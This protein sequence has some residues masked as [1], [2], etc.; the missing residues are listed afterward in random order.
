MEKPAIS[1]ARAYAQYA[2]DLGV[3]PSKIFTEERSQETLGN[4]LF[5]KMQILLPNDWKRIIVVPQ[6]NHM[7]DR[8]DYILQKVL[9]PDYE[10]A[11]VRA[12][13]NVDESNIAR[14]MK[15]LELT[16][17]IN[18]AFEDGDH[19]G[20]YKGL[21]ASHPAYGGTL[22]TVDELRELLS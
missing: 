4:I 17:Q 1:E 11:V 2:E 10:W 16:M 8:I 7:N 21:I 22:K 5:T 6:V 19:D 15:S 20:I 12:G 18:D 9:G 3:D 14:E 13:M